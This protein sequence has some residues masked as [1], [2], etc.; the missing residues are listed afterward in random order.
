MEPPKGKAVEQG[1][2]PSTSR[3]VQGLYRPPPPGM[4][5]VLPT[6]HT[7]P[8]E[9]LPGPSGVFQTPM[10]SFQRP[11]ESSSGPGYHPGAAARFLSGPIPQY[12]LGAGPIY[13]QASDLAGI[14]A[15]YGGS[16]TNL[17]TFGSGYGSS[18]VRSG[19]VYGPSSA[20]TS[21]RPSQRPRPQPYHE[22]THVHTQTNFHSPTSSNNQALPQL[23]SQDHKSQLTHHKTGHDSLTPTSP[24]PSLP[25]SLTPRTPP[26]RRLSRKQTLFNY[27]ILK[28]AFCLS[29]PPVGLGF[30]SSVAAKYHHHTTDDNEVSSQ[31]F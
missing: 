14:S 6:T 13:G 24:S 17:R 20:P 22:R 30:S 29:C 16:A 15:V 27:D 31:C 19:A 12:G 11:P 26:G 1:P 2:G 18:S 25:H 23:P 7:R 8:S 5:Q 3:V 10:A 28:N 4:R 9:E 21:P